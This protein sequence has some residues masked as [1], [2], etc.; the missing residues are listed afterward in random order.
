MFGSDVQPHAPTGSHGLAGFL[1]QVLNTDVAVRMHHGASARGVDHGDVLANAIEAFHLE[2]PPVGPHGGASAIGSQHV[3]NLV[4][5]HRVVEGAD[6]EAELLGKVQ[7][8]HHFVGAVAV[9][10]HDDLAV[11]H[12]SQRFVL[13]VARG[14]LRV[15]LGGAVALVLG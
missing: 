15:R 1:V 10:L 8:L 4:G 3:G 11:Q 5:L 2:A 13:Q 9:V 12:T 14:R 6:T 7:H